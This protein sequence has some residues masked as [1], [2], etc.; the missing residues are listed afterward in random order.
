MLIQFQQMWVSWP[1]YAIHAMRTN[2]MCGA[3]R[4]CTGSGTGL[5]KFSSACACQPLHRTY[6]DYRG[7]DKNMRGTIVVM[8]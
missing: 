3:H 8:E 2:R 7:T 5:G 4:R 6:T 1:S